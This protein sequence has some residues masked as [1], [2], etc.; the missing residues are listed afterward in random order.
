MIE[1]RISSISCNREEFDKVKDWYN[2]GLKNSG[3]D[4]EISYS[5]QTTLKTHWCNILWFNSPY[6]ASIKTNIGK[7]FLELVNKH[8]PH[9]FHKIFNQNT[10]RISYS[11]SPDMNAII[12]RQNKKILKQAANC[13]NMLA[14]M[15]AN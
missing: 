3:F 11:C 4:Y 13:P 15:L 9:R 2:S 6:K 14:N 5:E 8:F 10:I 7:S 12:S 1:D